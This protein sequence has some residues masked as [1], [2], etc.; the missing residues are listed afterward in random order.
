MGAAKTAARAIGGGEIQFAVIES[1]EYREE[2]ARERR[3]HTQAQGSARIFDG[4]GWS[5]QWV[6]SN[7]GG[8]GLP[9]HGTRLRHSAKACQWMRAITP[10]VNSG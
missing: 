3:H 4:H 2:V 6:A 1:R 9:N 8:A 10:T 7:T 5:V